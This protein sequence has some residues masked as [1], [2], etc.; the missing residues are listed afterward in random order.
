MKTEGKKTEEK[1]SE[2]K[3]TAKREQRALLLFL[4]VVTVIVAVVFGRNIY[5]RSRHSKENAKVLDE[6]ALYGE[7][8][9][10][11]LEAK[12]DLSDFHFRVSG[13]G[14]YPDGTKQAGD[15]FIENPSDNKYHMQVTITDKNSGEGLY[16]SAVLAP[17]ENESRFA[18]NAALS[19]GSHTATAHISAIDDSTKEPVGEV[20][21]DIR[22]EVG[23]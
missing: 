22:L 8:A 3:K 7:Q 9:G 21:A 10:A 2:E 16:K 17:G 14:R 23:K 20:T 5:Q 18:L 12:S 19:E 13:E 6:S 1:K 4:I 15:L 11:Q